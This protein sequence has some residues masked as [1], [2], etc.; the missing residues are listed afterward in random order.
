MELLSL[1]VLALMVVNLVM[2]LRLL[3]KQARVDSLEQQLSKL[4]TTLKDEFGRNR[5]EMQKSSRDDRDEFNQAMRYFTATQQQQVKDLTEHTEKRLDS[6]KAAV[7]QRLEAIQLDNNSKLEKMRLTV[8]EKLHKTLED[9]L[10]ESFKLVSER[11]ELVHKGLGEMQSLAS[12]VGDL[13]RVLSNVKTRGILGE[14]Q[15]EN[16]LEQILSAHQ[17]AKNVVT[18]RDSRDRVEFAIKLPGKEDPEDFIYLPVDAK[19]PLEAYY[20]L[21]DAYE[22]GD[23]QA[24]DEKG[25]ELETII[26]KCA[27]DIRDKYIDPPFTTDFAILFLPIEGLYAEAVRRPG[28]IETL[29]K[30]YR[31]NITGPTTLAALLNSLQMGFKTLAIERHSSEVWKILGAVKGEFEKFG[32]VL[33]KTQARLTQ[34]SQELDALVGVRTRQIQRKLK[35][36]QSLPPQEAPNYLNEQTE[37]TEEGA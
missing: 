24:V 8:D 16:I 29:Q 14:I 36:V 6:L 4:E 26:K 25:K 20:G 28:L 11:L 10:G 37:E 18:K 5:M 22:R 1:G 23:Q 33:G 17:Y 34:A 7:E 32:D 12:G 13:K 3:G 30:D 35:A 15:L 9:R 21:L 19:F 2:V 27:R 31:I